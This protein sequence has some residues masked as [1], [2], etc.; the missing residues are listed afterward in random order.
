MERKPGLTGW[1]LVGLPGLWI[2]ACLVG[3]GPAVA[4]TASGKV[5]ARG[6]WQLSDDGSLVIHTKTGSAW[7]RCAE[8]M[9]WTGKACTGEPRLLSHAD[10][11]ALA[12]A[13]AKADGVR[14]RLPRVTELQRLVKRGESPHRLDPV[15]FPGGPREWHWASTANV[16][17][18]SVNPYNYGNVMRG[19]NADNVNQMAFL[20]GWAVNLS[21]GD[22]DSETPKRNLLPVRLVRPQP[23]ESTDR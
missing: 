5:T 11:L 12:A 18:Q 4:A 15:L 9:S 16:R 10:A 22:A 23:R 7:K 19:V 2:A 3:A 20:H 17:Q 13:T 1:G 14:W 21:S 6:D 8:G